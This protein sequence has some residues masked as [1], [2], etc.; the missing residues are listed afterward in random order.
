VPAVEIR[1]EQAARNTRAPAV[2]IRDEQA[3]R[4]TRAIQ[5]LSFPFCMQCRKPTRRGMVS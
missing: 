5:T 4:N 2:E 3:A 1:D